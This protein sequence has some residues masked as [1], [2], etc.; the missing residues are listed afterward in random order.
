VTRVK[1]TY[2]LRN[3]LELRKSKAMYLRKYINIIPCI[4][5]DGGG[6]PQLPRWACVFMFIEVAIVPA[7]FSVCVRHYS[8]VELPR[9]S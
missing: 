7:R 6:A 3:E 8:G 9:V 4:G 1:L 5:D 2:E